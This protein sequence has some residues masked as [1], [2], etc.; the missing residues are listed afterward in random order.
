MISSSFP[1]P[2]GNHTTDP[3]CYPSL[4][5]VCY[6][7]PRSVQWRGVRGDALNRLY[8][9]FHGVGHFGNFLGVKRPSVALADFISQNPILDFHKFENVA[10][11][12]EDIPRFRRSVKLRLVTSHRFGFALELVAYV[13]DERMANIMIG[14]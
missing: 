13:N 6:P 7:C 11:R 9:Q 3:K 10:G 14:S 8:G 4:R 1:E 12:R 2:R 5:H